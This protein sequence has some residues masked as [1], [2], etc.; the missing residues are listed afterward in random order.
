MSFSFWPWVWQRCRC[1]PGLPIPTFS[2]DGTMKNVNRTLKARLVELLESAAMALLLMTLLFPL[3]LR[4]QI[5]GS[6]EVK[7]FDAS[8]ASVP[9]ANVKARSLATGTL[10]SAIT[11]ELGVALISQL[12]IG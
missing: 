2:G 7:V 8:Q 12:A 11:N 6:I 1:L 3:A 9:G 10:R 5:S 4:A